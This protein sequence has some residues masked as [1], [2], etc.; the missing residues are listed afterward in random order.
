MKNG[1]FTLYYSEE[2]FFLRINS[3]LRTVIPQVRI[4]FKL[5]NA[6]MTVNSVCVCLDMKL[7]VIALQKDL[8][9]SI[10]RMEYWREQRGL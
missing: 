1:E 10:N 6:Q 8:R 7:I 5:N 9:L 4:N 3:D 2:V